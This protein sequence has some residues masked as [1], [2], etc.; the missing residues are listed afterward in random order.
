[1]IINSGIIADCFIY[2]RIFAERWVFQ[3]PEFTD[4]LLMEDNEWREAFANLYEQSYEGAPNPIN[5]KW[6]TILIKK[7][8]VEDLNMLFSATEGISDRYTIAFFRFMMYALLYRAYNND[9]LNVPISPA[10]PKWFRARKWHIPEEWNCLK[11]EIA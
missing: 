7:G 11:G 3:P 8:E 6:F 9:Q 5:T 2:C 10:I 1:M 4:I